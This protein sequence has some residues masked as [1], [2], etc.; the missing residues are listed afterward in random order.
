[1]NRKGIAALLAL[2]LLIVLT[3]FGLSWMTDHLVEARMDAPVRVTVTPEPV[4]D[5]VG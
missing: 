1:M 4:W 2:L 3:L 5:E